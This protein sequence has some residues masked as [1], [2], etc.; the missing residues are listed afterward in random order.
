MGMSYEEAMMF[1]SF[2][3]GNDYGPSIRDQIAE[4]KEEMFDAVKNVLLDVLWHHNA[5]VA[6]S[7]DGHSRMR[8]QFD[9]CGY[10]CQLYRDEG[11]ESK[12]IKSWD[13]YE[14]VKWDRV[15]NSVHEHTS[16]EE[17]RK[18]LP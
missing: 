8:L 12:V 5:I 3:P 14:D 9:D 6:D 4:L 15:E 7:I 2:G 1:S 18:F 13:S 10:F 16:K 11:I 17:Y